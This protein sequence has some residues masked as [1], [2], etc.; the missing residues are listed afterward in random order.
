LKRSVDKY[1]DFDFFP[2]F[3]VAHDPV[4]VTDPLSQQVPVFVGQP[5]Q[6]FDSIFR[7]GYAM[8]SVLG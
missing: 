2:G 4:R 1:L 7:A 5:N 8:R 3:I 6:A